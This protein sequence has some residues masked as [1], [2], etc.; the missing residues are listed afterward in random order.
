MCR[1]LVSAN[2]R[3]GRQ[4]SRAGAARDPD[5]ADQHAGR[6][7]SSASFLHQSG[8]CQHGRAGVS[9]R[10]ATGSASTAASRCQG[11]AR[12]V[13]PGPTAGCAGARAVCPGAGER[14]AGAEGA[15]HPRAVHAAAAA[16]SVRGQCSRALLRARRSRSGRD[17]RAC[18]P[19]RAARCLRQSRK[20]GP[21]PDVRSMD[22]C[23][24]R[25]LPQHRVRSLLGDGAFRHLH[26]S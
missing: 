7:K 8:G 2:G 22:M 19:C 15:D 26:R 14:P 9:R 16:V 25:H 3:R 10:S 6:K 4:D 1:R 18:Q 23:G 24:R 5:F 11:C 17:D 20:C 13:S 21:G 12:P